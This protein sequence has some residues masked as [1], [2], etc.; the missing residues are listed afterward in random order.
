[1]QQNA[2]FVDGVYERIKNSSEYLENNAGK[3]I[4]LVFDNAPAH[5]QTEKRV[6]GG[7]ELVLLRL[8][9]YSPMC[10]PIEGMVT[11]KTIMERVSNTG[12]CDL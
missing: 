7:D 12:V 11:T 10:N 6:R 8:G 4:V 1:M 3:K 9:P 5:N 2:D